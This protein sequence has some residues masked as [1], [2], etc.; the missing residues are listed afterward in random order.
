MAGLLDRLAATYGVKRQQDAWGKWSWVH[1]ASLSATTLRS[2]LPMLVST[3]YSLDIDDA[4]AVEHTGWAYGTVL[5]KVSGNAQIG[6]EA[7]VS[8]YVAEPIDAVFDTAKLVYVDDARKDLPIFY[9]DASYT[10]MIDT[11][12]LPGITT[13]LPWMDAANG[14]AD[15]NPHVIALKLPV[16]NMALSAGTSYLQG[17]AHGM[18]WGIGLRWQVDYYPEELEWYSVDTLHEYL[19]RSSHDAQSYWLRAD[20]IR[21]ANQIL[22]GGFNTANP[23]LHSETRI[24][25]SLIANLSFSKAFRRA[26]T[27]SLRMSLTRTWS[28]LPEDAPVD[29]M[30]WSWI[31]RLGWRVDLRLK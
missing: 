25:N 26:G 27:V 7:L 3:S 9:R 14:T 17:L 31:T 23:A 16:T 1:D 10:D 2:R 21:I 24:D 12:G 20:T 6:A 8:A 30:E 15:A 11:T 22:E 18:R 28:S 19:G 29:I 13:I 5:F 4:G